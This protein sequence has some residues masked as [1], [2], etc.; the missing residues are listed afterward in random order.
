MLLTWRDPRARLAVDTATEAALTNSSYNNG[1]GC[2]VRAALLVDGL[3]GCL[4]WP[5]WLCFALRGSCCFH[6]CP[7]P[8]SSHRPALSSCLAPP[9]TRGQPTARQGPPGERAYQGSWSRQHGL[10]L[11][12]AAPTHA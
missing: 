7:M 10:L 6:P 9:S 5:L 2:A 12:P 4:V 1:N 8:P 11:A 3:L